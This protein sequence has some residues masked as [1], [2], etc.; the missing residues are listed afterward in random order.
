MKKTMLYGHW[1]KNSLNRKKKP[2]KKKR[3]NRKNKSTNQI[4]S[5]MSKWNNDSTQ[6]YNMRKTVLEYHENG[7]YSLML[8]SDWSE[9]QQ[10]YI[11]A[12]KWIREFSETGLIMLWDYSLWNEE[13]GDWIPNWK[14]DFEY[15]DFENETYNAKWLYDAENENWYGNFKNESGYTDDNQLQW[16]QNYWWSSDMSDWEGSSYYVNMYDDDG[17]L[18]KVVN[19]GWDT[20]EWDW[21]LNKK[22]YYYYRTIMDIDDNPASALQLYP[23]PASSYL[24]INLSDN[25][26]VNLSI[27]TLNGMLVKEIKNYKSENMISIDELRNGVYLMQVNNSNL[28]KFVKL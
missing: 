28:M 27:Y 19:F 21:Y 9:E 4:L 15:D 5:Y 12:R 11:Q 2:L 14:H 1:L 25:K 10:D 6:W 23:N 20:E 24:Y 18:C 13:K 7:E 16:Y 26:N 8:A 22:D 17:F 3:I